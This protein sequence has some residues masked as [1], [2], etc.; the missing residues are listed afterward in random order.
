M[1]LNTDS[2]AG[3]QKISQCRQQPDAVPVLILNQLWLLVTSSQCHQLGPT[4]TPASISKQQIHQRQTAWT[5][6]GAA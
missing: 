2:K 5:Y 3:Q 6:V 4:S 1:A